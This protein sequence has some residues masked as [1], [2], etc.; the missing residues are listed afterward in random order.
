MKISLQLQIELKG[1]CAGIT[2]TQVERTAT[3]ALYKRSDGY[4]ECF[5]IIERRY[6]YFKDGFWV[7]TTD[8]IERYPTDECFGA[9]AWC[10]SEK[11]IREVYDRLNTVSDPDV[12]H[13]LPRSPKSNILVPLRENNG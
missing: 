2:A 4:W 11:T 10:G 6:N 3:K 7:Q 1:S 8:T 13:I 12:L 5:R 9:S